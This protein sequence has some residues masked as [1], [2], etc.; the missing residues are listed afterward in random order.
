MA[1]TS[2]QS[3]FTTLLSLGLVSAI[4]QAP[5]SENKPMAGEENGRPPQVDSQGSMPVADEMGETYTSSFTFNYECT[6]PTMA[7]G[8]NWNNDPANG[9]GTLEPNL[10]HANVGM[11]ATNSWVYFNNWNGPNANLNK[12]WGGGCGQCWELTPKQEYNWHK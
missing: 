10:D 2:F 11:A 4:P 1:P 8:P 7:C 3:L 5:Y 6:G 9:P 12:G